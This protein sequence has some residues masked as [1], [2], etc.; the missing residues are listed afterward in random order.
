MAAKELSKGNLVLRILL[1]IAYSRP[2][3]AASV[4]IGT[5][6]FA[7]IASSILVEALP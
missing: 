4:L 2:G 1:E 3:M 6:S 7:I 5:I